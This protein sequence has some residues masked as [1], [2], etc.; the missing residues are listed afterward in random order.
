[1]RS[2]KAGFLAGRSAAVWEMRVMADE[3]LL[4][5]WLQACWCD[6]R[7]GNTRSGSRL[8]MV[9]NLVD[10]IRTVRPGYEEILFVLTD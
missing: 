6:G 2:V 4:E 3:E 8:A 5:R 1:M 7:F 9:T 10:I